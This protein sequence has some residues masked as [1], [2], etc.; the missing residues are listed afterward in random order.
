VMC[1]LQ[2]AGR[3]DKS[4]CRMLRNR[5]RNRSPFAVFLTRCC[6]GSEY[7]HARQRA[8]RQ[9]LAA[10][11]G[12]KRG[13][14]NQGAESARKHRNE[15]AAPGRTRRNST[16]DATR[17]P[18]DRRAVASACFGDPAHSRRSSRAA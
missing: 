11:R 9:R 13:L 14:S 2:T 17:A 6:T 3:D 10:L 15:S 8:G 12:R 16:A 5:K 1:P 4:T 18:R 7:R